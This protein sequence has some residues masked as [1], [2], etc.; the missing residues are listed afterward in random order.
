MM[1][2][3]TEMEEIMVMGMME[4]I[5]QLR[6]VLWVIN[7]NLLNKLADLPALFIVQY[8]LNRECLL[9]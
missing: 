9:L 6:V 8:K 4:G 7:K 3:M 2:V 5:K 1:T